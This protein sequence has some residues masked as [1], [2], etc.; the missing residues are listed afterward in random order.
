MD[1]LTPR[2]QE[3]R[4]WEDRAV[5]IWSSHYPQIA[6]VSTDKDKPCAVDAILVKDKQIV[7]VVE[8][9]SRP[10]LTVVEFMGDHKGEWLVTHQKIK[11]GVAI[12][13]ALHTKFVG[14]LYL[15]E[16]DL[17]MFKTIWHPDQGWTVPIK[18]HETKTQ[19]TINGGIAV[20]EN[21]FIDM[22]NAT[23]LYGDADG[24]QTAE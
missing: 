17:L 22:K 21:A 16:A 19:A 1:I 9:K 10:S 12:A 13:Q 15:P 23:V 6:Y 11:D 20:R 4:K 5:D 14:F 8:Q 7:G 24:R 3:S 2:G 18:V